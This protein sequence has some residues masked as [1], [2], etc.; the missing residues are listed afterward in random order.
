MISEAAA[1]SLTS[2]HLYDLSKTLD[3]R[4]QASPGR[5]TPYCKH[6]KGAAENSVL[7]RAIP[8]DKIVFVW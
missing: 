8:V 6:Y 1:K 4:M 7:L 2:E 5:F 3:S